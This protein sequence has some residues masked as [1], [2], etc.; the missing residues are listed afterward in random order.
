[1]NSN[2]LSPA[3]VAPIQRATPDIVSS[4]DETPQGQDQSGFSDNPGILIKDHD[5]S[6]EDSS[7]QSTKDDISSN[8]SSLQSTKGL[9]PIMSDKLMFKHI[10]GTCTI[11]FSFT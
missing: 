9:Y 5:I 3:F 1:M 7:L 4:S 8:N 11:G 10:H 2:R 6:S